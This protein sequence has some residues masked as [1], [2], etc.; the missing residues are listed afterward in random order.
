[1][2]EKEE[3]QDTN[4][5]LLDETDIP[6]ASLNGKS[7]SELNV[8][9]LRRWLACRAPVNGKKPELIEKVSFLFACINVCNFPG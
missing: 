9:Q 8:T 6:G 1:M 7:P 3:H 2:E 5:S 4:V